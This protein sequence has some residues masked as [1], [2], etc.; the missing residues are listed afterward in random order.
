MIIRIY[1]N[2]VNATNVVSIQSGLYKQDTPRQ[3]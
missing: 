1:K 2:S 3:I